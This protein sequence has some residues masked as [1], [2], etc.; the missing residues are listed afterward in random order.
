[1]CE[2]A[3]RMGLEGIVSKLIDAPYRSGPRATWRKA[4]NPESDAVR[5]GGTKVPARLSVTLHVPF[6]QKIA[7]VVND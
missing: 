7:E 1:M 4:K 6:V 5:R 2:D 3:C